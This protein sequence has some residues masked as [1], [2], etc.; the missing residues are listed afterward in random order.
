MGVIPRKQIDQLA[1]C[2]SHWP[3]WLAE[4]TNIGT[5]AGAI[6]SFKGLT[7]DARA[8]WDSWESVKATY[9]AAL[10]DRILRLGLAV[11]NAADLIKAIKGF[12]AQQALPGEVYILAQIP[13]PAMP[14]PVPAPGQPTNIGIGLSSNGSITLKWKSTNASASSGTFFTVERRLLGETNFSLIG[15]VGVK[16]FV[17]ST[18]TLGTTGCTYIITGKRGTLTGTASEQIGVQFG[19]GGGGGL[20]VTNATI[21]P[22]NGKMKMAA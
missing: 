7:I 16:Q 3:V 20:A 18:I 14:Q 19:V 4:A 12:A 5:S 1:F 6:N 9:D 21:E 17:D 22:M 10:A 15:T 2:E 13:A 11:S 8:A